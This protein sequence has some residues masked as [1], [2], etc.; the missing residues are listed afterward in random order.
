MQILQCSF[1]LIHPLSPWSWLVIIPSWIHFF[2]INSEINMIILPMAIMLHEQMQINDLQEICLQPSIHTF[3]EHGWI[4]Q[5]DS[6]FLR[7]FHFSGISDISAFVLNIFYEILTGMCDVLTLLD[8]RYFLVDLTW[9][10][11][12]TAPPWKTHFWI[13]YEF[14]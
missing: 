10:G 12:E 8:I 6:D 5:K 14:K 1:K 9:G 7:F 3:G 2:A 11:A 4:I 13:F